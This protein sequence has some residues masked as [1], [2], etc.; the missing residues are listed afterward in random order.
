MKRLIPAAVFMILVVVLWEATIPFLTAEG[1]AGSIGLMR[2]DRWTDIMN[3]LV[4]FKA[5]DKPVDINTAFR[6]IAEKSAP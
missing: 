4:E 6:N 3:Q 5:L 2:S 1:G